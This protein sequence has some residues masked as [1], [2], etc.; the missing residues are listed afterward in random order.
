M[1]Q[2]KNLIGKFKVP[3]ITG[4]NTAIFGNLLIAP[5]RINPPVLL[6]SMLKIIG[7]QPFSRTSFAPSSRRAAIAQ[8]GAANKN[9]TTTATLSHDSVRWARRNAD[10]STH[11]GKLKQSEI[12][13]FE[14]PPDTLSDVAA[15]PIIERIRR[16]IQC[17]IS[18]HQSI[19]FS[20]LDIT[21]AEFQEVA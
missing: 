12:H 15:I 19:M 8:R 21:G 3:F 5:S 17:I 13:A 9:I 2:H 7:D 16:V 4:W 1:K 20:G 18:R 14:A 10:P 11:V 6:I